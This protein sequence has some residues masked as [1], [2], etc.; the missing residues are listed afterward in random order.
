LP[1]VSSTRVRALL[2]RR[3]ETE[4]RKELQA[5]VPREVLA[6]IDREGLYR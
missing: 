2:R 4:A 5:L 3:D 1:D 6:Y